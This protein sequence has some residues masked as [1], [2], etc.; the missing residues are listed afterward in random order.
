MKKALWIAGGIAVVIGIVVAVAWPSRWEILSEQLESS[1]MSEPFVG[2]TNNGA[3]EPDLFEIRQTGVSAAPMVDAARAFL[4]SLT[5]TQR[6]SVQFPVD[7]PEWRKWMNP[8]FYIRQGVAFLDMDDSQRAAAF[9]MMGAGLSVKGFTLARDIMKLNTTL[10]EL[11]DNDFEEYGEW[12]YWITIMGEPSYDQPWGWQLDGHHLIINYFV[13]GDQVV[14]TPLF[15]GSEPVIATSGKYQ[16]VAIL[17]DEQRLGLEVMRSLTDAQVAEAVLESQK[18]GNNNLAEFFKDNVI[19]DYA[20]TSVANFSREQQR[21]LMDLVSLYI[22]NMD[23]G[24]AQNRMQMLAA[25]LDETY[26]AWVGGLEDDSVYYY[27]VHSP[28]LLIE[29]DHQ[30][31]IGLRHLTDSTLP[32]RDH[33][34]AVVRTPNGNDYGKD[35]LR[36]HLERYPHVGTA[37][38]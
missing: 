22:G 34:H 38:T 19:I 12:R 3:I 24:H 26:F 6:T 7:D 4:A 32:Q 15:V 27:R 14:M 21:K 1:A 11:N 35:L 36:Q 10:A 20:G 28:V 31:P 9:E 18:T 17:Q 2:I 8:H 23:V 25:H 29:F 37:A 16:G 30:K 13:L 33:V 5:D